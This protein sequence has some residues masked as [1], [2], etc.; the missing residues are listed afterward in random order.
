L[1]SNGRFGER[2]QLF[3]TSVDLPR[4]PFEQIGYGANPA[5]T[6]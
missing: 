2:L 3:K 6:A 4:D 5:S 1:E